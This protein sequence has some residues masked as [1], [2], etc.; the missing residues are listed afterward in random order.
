MRIL[1]ITVAWA[2]TFLFAA[3]SLP[4]GAITGDEIVPDPAF[5]RVIIET[6]LYAQPYDTSGVVMRLEIGA[7]GEILRDISEEWYLLRV[8][9]KVGWAP[10]GALRF[11]PDMPANCIPL[12]RRYLESYVQDL[13][14]PTGWLVLTEIHRQTT[15]VF[16]HSGKWRLVRSMPCST[17]KNTSP[18]TRG[19]FTLTGRGEWF[20]SERLGSGGR[21]WV[22]FNGTYLFHSVAM[23]RN[24]KVIDS[25]IGERASNGCVRLTELDAEWFYRTV[26]DG[27]AVLII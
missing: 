5:C 12:S 13:E 18:T 10:S 21:H 26:P 27:S 22:R 25:T 9:D 23:D 1:K 19:E 3:F 14:S 8:G 2:L 15:H 6:P 20:Y 24:K 7:V 4:D 16:R 11:D 17:G